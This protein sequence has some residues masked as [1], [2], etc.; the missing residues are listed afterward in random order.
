MSHAISYARSSRDEN[1]DSVKKQ[2]KDNA[3]Y[4]KTRGLTI[5]A[6]HDDS[7]SGYE[8]LAQ[9][10][11]LMKALDLCLDKGI[12]DIVITNVS[13]LTRSLRDG[14]LLLDWL[15]RH[16]IR[17]HL[18][19]EQRV[20]EEVGY[21]DLIRELADAEDYYWKFA[22]GKAAQAND[23]IYGK[24]RPPNGY[25]TDKGKP[26]VLVKSS[27][28]AE[29]ERIFAQALKLRGR[30]PKQSLSGIAAMIKS[31][32]YGKAAV[33]KMLEN[34]IY[35]GRKAP[36]G[37]IDIS[38]LRLYAGIHDAYVSDEDF[39]RLNGGRVVRHL[40]YSK[41]VVCE[42]CSQKE[43]GDMFKHHLLLNGQNLKCQSCSKNINISQLEEMMREMC[44]DYIF[45]PDLSAEYKFEHLSVIAQLEAIFKNIAHQGQVGHGTGV[46]VPN[47]PTAIPGSHKTAQI[48]IWE[49]WLELKRKLKKQ[50]NMAR[51]DIALHFSCALRGEN[52]DKDIKALLERCFAGV[53]VQFGRKGSH[54][55]K[56][57]KL[58]TDVIITQNRVG[59]QQ[60]AQDLE[61]LDNNIGKRMQVL[62]TLLGKNPF[63]MDY[64]AWNTVDSSFQQWGSFVS[65]AKKHLLY[66]P[67]I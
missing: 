3:A 64:L 46:F 57:I 37:T 35:T 40:E 17:L 41:L 34:P 2:H 42:A 50:L 22:R 16:G 58:A 14:V 59:D 54:V 7:I 65:Y 53:Y 62:R 21:L 27:D 63:L 23:S 51:D 52:K 45:D 11:D 10:R 13:R 26:G 31:D 4:A 5:H 28:A 47:A 39:I 44:R 12:R 25:T 56:P 43:K 9:H 33:R 61:T 36:S 32:K 19:K 30:L 67:Y 38:A 55:L 6:K 8:N 20:H 60:F 49:Q 48:E 15:H 66:D 1:S 24:G 18:S 29:V